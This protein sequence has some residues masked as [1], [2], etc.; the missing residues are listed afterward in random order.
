MKKILYLLLSLPLLI[1]AQT[2]VL[3]DYVFNMST[4]INNFG[5][6]FDEDST[7]YTSKVGGYFNGISSIT[8]DTSTYSV[9]VSGT[10]INL[11]FMLDEITVNNT[12]G[13]TYNI[14]NLQTSNKGFIYYK[15]G[16]VQFLLQ[17]SY[18][19]KD[20]FGFICFNSYLL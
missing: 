10:S 13:I 19:F 7:D 8:V 17:E 9:T 11:N 15:D 4:E 3:D 20:Y 1:N 6:T 2:M 18:S 12:G 5:G 16:I 14:I